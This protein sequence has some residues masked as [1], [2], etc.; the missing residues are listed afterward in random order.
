MMM[1]MMMPRRP[2]SQVSA[3][4]HALLKVTVV[5]QIPRP[6]RTVAAKSVEESPLHIDM[7]LSGV[8]RV[9]NRLKHY[10]LKL[11]II[12]DIQTASEKNIQQKKSKESPTNSCKMFSKA[13]GRNP[14]FRNHI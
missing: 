1:I 13:K 2:W 7:K 14:M 11:N 6:E 12:K 8:K 10:N 5:V 9:L 3:E 4:Q